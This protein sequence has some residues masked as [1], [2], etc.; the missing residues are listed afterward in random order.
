MTWPD[1]VDGDDRQ[2]RDLG[3]VEVHLD[4][5]DGGRPAERR[6]GV[7]AVGGVVEGAAGVGREALVDPVVAVR[8]GV[9]APRQA[10]RPARP[11]L[12]L[13]LEPPRGL[14]QQPAD[15]HR[16]A[17]GHRRPGV[18][19]ERRVLGRHLDVVDVDAELRR[20][21]LREDRLRPLPHLRR[22]REDP[23]PAVVRA[24]E[25]RDR[26]HL[27]LARAG[28]ARRRARPARGRCRGPSARRARAPP[29]SAAVFARTRSNSLASAARSRTSIAATSP[30]SSWFVGVTPPGR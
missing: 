9:V 4:L 25:A 26:A 11:A 3:R 13:R 12:D 18:G 15:D 28:E 14:D 16:R 30:R 21:Q 7:A 1:V 10:E 5:R 6:V 20:D 17:R 24:L 19:H 22:R 2:H 29:R 23:D 27:L 8:P